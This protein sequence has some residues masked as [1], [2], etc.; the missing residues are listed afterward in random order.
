MTRSFETDQEEFWA[1]TFGDD[2]VDRNAAKQISARKLARFASIIRSTG[3]ITSALELGANVGLNLRAIR[4]LQPDA[5]IAGVEINDRAVQQLATL[6]ECEVHHTSI[7]DWGPTKRYDLV[8]TS[9][10]LIHLQ[11]SRLDEVYDLM[12]AAADRFVMIAE[13]YNPTPVALDYRGHRDRLFKRDFAGEFLDRHP[14]F[15]L[16]DYAFE[17]R[18][19]VFGSDDITWF[20]LRRML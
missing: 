12:A 2:Y 11:P 7:L 8:F 6:D 4:T 20:L 9:G 1:G 13:Y 3:P 15:E 14:D 10:V 5:A 19:A 17:Y 16:V 18:R